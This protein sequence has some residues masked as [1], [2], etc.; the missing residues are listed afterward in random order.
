MKSERC[1]LF[2]GA[3]SV[4][5]WNSEGC[6]ERPGMWGCR[7]GSRAVETEEERWMG[8]VWNAGRLPRGVLGRKHYSPDSCQV[9]NSI[10]ELIFKAV[11]VVGAAPSLLSL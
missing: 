9:L 1:E 5:L 11:L 2:V 4:D 8:D 10:P 7:G 3:E 6:R